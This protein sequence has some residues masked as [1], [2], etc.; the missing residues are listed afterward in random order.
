VIYETEDADDPHGLFYRWTPPRS[1]RP[2]GR[3]S[4]KAL[5]DEAGK[6]E[7]MRARL[8]GK[9]APDL[10]V[11]TKIGTTYGVQWVTVP[12]RDASTTP[13]RP[14][15]QRIVAGGRQEGDQE[16]RQDRHP[17]PQARRRLVGP[18]RRLSRRVLRPHRRRQRV[19]H[20]GQVWFLDTKHETIG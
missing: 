4:L 3:S 2:L 7:A 19:Q 5:R 17:Q 20:D 16:E 11:A 12:D 8:H 10:C 1:A 13:V 9:L 14:P 6:L 18:R 15:V